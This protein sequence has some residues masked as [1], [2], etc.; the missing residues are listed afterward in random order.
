MTPIV[1]CIGLL[2]VVI[3]L[4]GLRSTLYSSMTKSRHIALAMAVGVAVALPVIWLFSPNS[5]TEPQILIGRWVF[6]PVCLLAVFC[7]S[8]LYDLI[9][10]RTNLNY[11]YVR[12]PLEIVV[13]IPAWTFVWG[14]ICII[15]E[16]ISVE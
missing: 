3:A 6:P 11:W 15:I 16:W 2:G 13:G 8:C 14:W 1:S 12:F 7:V 4:Y 5:K 10:G 9:K